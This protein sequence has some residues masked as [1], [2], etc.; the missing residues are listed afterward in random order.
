MRTQ[1]VDTRI[2]HTRAHTHKYRL[3]PITGKKSV[4]NPLAFISCVAVTIQC[5]RNCWELNVCA[6]SSCKAFEMILIYYYANEKVKSAWCGEVSVERRKDE[7][8]KRKNPSHVCDQ[9]FILIIM[10]ILSKCQMNP[11]TFDLWNAFC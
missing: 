10:H 8:R 3:T 9:R 7:M 11:P 6:C 2:T 4:R 5:E 1:C